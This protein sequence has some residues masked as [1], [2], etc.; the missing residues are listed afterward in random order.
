MS[1]RSETERMKWL[2]TVSSQT[3]RG[4][5]GPQARPIQLYLSLQLSLSSSL[6]LTQPARRRRHARCHAPAARCPRPGSRCRRRGRT[7][8]RSTL[9]YS[10]MRRPEFSGPVLEG[11]DGKSRYFF[12][13]RSRE[14]QT[15]RSTGASPA[16]LARGSGWHMASTRCLPK[17]WPP[18]GLVVAFVAS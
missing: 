4:A 14:L 9:V 17:G 6:S 3:W 5:P 7:C 13:E 18:L 15:R 1:A 10:T 8:R 11:S 12:R 2:G 16:G